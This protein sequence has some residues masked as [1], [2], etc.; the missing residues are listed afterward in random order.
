[1]RGWDRMAEAAL[2]EALEVVVERIVVLVLDEDD[3]CI[4]STPLERH[5]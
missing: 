3:L 4:D 1:M 2:R 5:D